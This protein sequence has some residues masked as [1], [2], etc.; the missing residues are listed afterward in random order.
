MALGIQFSIHG[1]QKLID[2][3]EFEVVFLLKDNYY[4]VLIDGA[5]A[6]K[7]DSILDPSAEGIGLAIPSGS[8]EDFGS[9]CD[10][11]NIDLW[12]IKEKLST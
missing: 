3:A 5:T 12:A 7:G 2:P 4:Q 6:I 8:D 1:Y 10:F 11:T 9:Q